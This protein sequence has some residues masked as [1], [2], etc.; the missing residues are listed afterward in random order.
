MYL[1]INN[2]RKVRGSR[3]FICEIFIVIGSVILGTL[4][5]MALYRMNAVANFQNDACMV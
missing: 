3:F 5:Q 4:A 2:D 1:L